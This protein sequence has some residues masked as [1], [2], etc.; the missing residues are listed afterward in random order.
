[1]APSVS[2]CPQ[3]ASYRSKVRSETVGSVPP[4]R[5]DVRL[6]SSLYLAFLFPFDDTGG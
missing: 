4:S 2:G 1:M 6:L 5:H 3:K